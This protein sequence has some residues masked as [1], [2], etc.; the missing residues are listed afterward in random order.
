MVLK[1]VDTLTALN[2]IVAAPKTM[3]STHTIRSCDTA[4]MLK[5]LEKPPAGRGRVLTH[6][7]PGIQC[8][9]CQKEP[10]VYKTVFFGGTRE[11]VDEDD[12]WTFV[13]KKRQKRWLG[14]E[15]E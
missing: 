1:K 5:N 14:S 3:P 11:Y 12:G 7:A 15:D 8:D 9:A 4:A 2:R 13:T 10:Y 6:H